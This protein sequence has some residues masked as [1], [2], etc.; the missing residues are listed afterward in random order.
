MLRY[1]SLY[2]S[3]LQLLA[4]DYRKISLSHESRC[5]IFPASQTAFL[6]QR[7]LFRNTNVANYLAFSQG[8]CTFRLS[9]PEHKLG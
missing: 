6:F 7:K 2:T 4:D 5:S 9:Y 8:E 1:T 3:P